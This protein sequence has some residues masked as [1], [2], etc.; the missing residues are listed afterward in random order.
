MASE[1]KLLFPAG[2][3]GGHSCLLLPSVPLQGESSWRTVVPTNRSLLPRNLRFI[4]DDAGVP[5]NFHV[6]VFLK[7]FIS[8]H[9][10]DETRAEVPRALAKELSLNC[11][12]GAE[13]RVYMALLVANGLGRVPPADLRH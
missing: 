7:G 3:G 6:K 11:D 4:M 8:L 13:A 12:E 5:A 9:G 2:Q 10:I 1:R